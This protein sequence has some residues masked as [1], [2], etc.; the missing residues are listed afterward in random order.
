MPGSHLEH[1]PQTLRASAE[2]LVRCCGVGK[3][4]RPATGQARLP[5]RSHVI[6]LGLSRSSSQLI[7]RLIWLRLTIQVVARGRDTAARGHATQRVEAE[8]GRGGSLTAPPLGPARPLLDF[9][10]PSL[11]QRPCRRAWSTGCQYAIER[12]APA[13]PLPTKRCC[14]RARSLTFRSLRYLGGFRSRG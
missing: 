6:H 1:A 4:A 11:L 10:S 3:V 9:P 14:H 13:A 8:G 2:Q 5:R 7:S 12:R